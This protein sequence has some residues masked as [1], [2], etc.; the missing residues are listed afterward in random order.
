MNEVC[1]I[2]E[3]LDYITSLRVQVDVMR[4]LAS[5]SARASEPHN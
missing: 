2:E 4:S 1:L 5:A 3:T